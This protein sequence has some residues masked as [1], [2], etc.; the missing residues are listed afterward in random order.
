M[1]ILQIVPSYPPKIGGVENHVFELV[2]RLRLL[3]HTVYVVTSNQPPL[4][5]KENFNF[6]KRLP[7]LFNASG[8]WGEIPICPSIFSALSD[9][10]P[11]IVHVHTPPRFFAECAA[12]YFRYMSSTRIPLVVTYHLHNSSLKNLGK[13]VWD[14]HNRT[15]QR[16]VFETA[17]KIVVCNSQDV[18]VMQ[19][20]FG[21]PRKKIVT[22]PPGVDCDRFNPKKVKANLFK[23]KGIS[24]NNIIL[25]TGRLNTVKGLNYLIQAFQ[26]VSEE[27]KDS[28]LVICGN[29][30]GNY[31]HDLENLTTTLNLSSRVVFLDPVSAQDYPSLLA[32]CD[33]FVLPSLS[34]SF[35][36]VTAEALSMEKPVVATR[37]T[38]VKEFVRNNET[39][40]M[41]EP[42]DVKALSNAIVELLK[43][44]ALAKKLG[45]NGRQ[46]VA[47]NFDWSMLARKFEALYE[48][49]IRG[50]RE[51]SSQSSVEEL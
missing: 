6:E 51:Y 17:D 42:R 44:R 19:Q 28:V 39:G 26:L 10:H 23:Q 47:S 2:R 31:K 37:V 40:L 1:R 14:L 21:V 49:S 20:E 29:G 45:Q 16:F 36:I 18:E 4:N 8:K 15:F 41:V 34:E 30:T 24:A 50:L 25:F 11:D 5:V 22:I 27:I 3:G 46:F 35:S 32:S 43:N 12:F 9:L 48:E 33:V 13:I 7:L 38:G